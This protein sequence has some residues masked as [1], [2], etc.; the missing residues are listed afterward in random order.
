MVEA[1][2]A[3]PDVPSP[4]AER[5]S[6]VEPRSGARSETRG[7]ALAL[8]GVVVGAAVAYG[9]VAQLVAM[10]LVNP[11]ELRYT[12]A[13]QGVA[14]GEWLNL[15]GE[16]YAYGAVYP[17]LLAPIL[18]LSGGVDAAYPLFKAAN[19]LLFALAAVPIY[20]LSR[21]L[22]SSWWSVGVAAGS[23][24]I[25]SS[26]YASMVMTES[27]SYLVSSTA[28]LAVV[29]AL[30]RP[31]VGRQL[32]M[33]AAVALAYATRPQ[34][35]S[36]AVAFLAGA[37]LL[38][39]LHPGRPTLRAS[40]VRLSPT[41]VAVTAGITILAVR[42]LLEQ[43][44]PSGS[45]AG[46]A[47]LW[48]QYDVDDVL[49]FF[50]YHLAAWEMYLFVVPFVVAPIVVADLVRAARRGAE[51]EGA[52]AVAFVTVNSA[53]LLI[54][55]AFASTVYGYS[56]LHDRYLF[57]VA[58][59]WLV[60]FAVWLSGGMP[61]PRLWTSLGVALGLILPAILPFGLI[62][63]NI[64]FEE[65][66]TA[67]W[68]WLWTV[69]ENTPH[70]D[71]RRILAGLV[72]AL[73]IAAVAVP[74]RLWPVLP[75]MVL[76]G[77]L[78]TSVLAWKREVD[79]PAEH[80]RS[81]QGNRAW[82]DDAVPHGS[83]VTKLYL[84]PPDCPYTEVT[85]HA[86]FL[87]EFFNASV[88]RAAAVGDSTQDSLPLLRVHVGHDGRFLRPDG[89]PLVAEYVVTQPGIDLAGRRVSEG[90]GAGLV[91]WQVRGV[92]SATHTPLRT[93]EMATGDCG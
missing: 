79:S 63:G 31:S 51:R 28:L 19:A 75:A 56:E 3:G 5:P 88:D 77:F 4:R 76:A 27:V 2:K 34:F 1:Q 17:L 71:G 64:V 86:L 9:L 52:F 12:I 68:S 36:L 49:R 87:T 89:R 8:V 7:T 85:R 84:S 48:R 10:P 13:A 32:A 67:L 33:L 58:P 93:S 69:V 43:S 83:R 78:L 73:T 54:A 40:V 20:L 46:Y 25:P 74:R 60:A 65:V 45:V 35:A 70:L 39:A 6:I 16:A 23:L 61:R 11:D 15:R 90:T 80:V 14:H 44:S 62:G 72:V 53:M 47:D 42:L 24:A 37:L 18:A 30:E 92:V 38:S 26:I 82:I 57:Y 91:L 29:L 55:G 66:P 22:L 21:R 50:V 59:L 41:L 81:D